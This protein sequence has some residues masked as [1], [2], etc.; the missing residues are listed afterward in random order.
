MCGG[1]VVVVAAKDTT[2]AEHLRFVR[3]ERSQRLLYG[4]AVDVGFSR[5]S[6]NRDIWFN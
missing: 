1:P 2:R 4:F 3:D 6:E 5:R